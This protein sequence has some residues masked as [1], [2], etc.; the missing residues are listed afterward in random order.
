MTYTRLLRA[1][2]RCSVVG[3]QRTMLMRIK[4]LDCPRRVWGASVGFQPSLMAT[5]RPQSSSGATLA[6][7]P[8][9]S[10]TKK[11]R[12]SEA[13]ILDYSLTV[14]VLYGPYASKTRRTSKHSLLS[15]GGG[16]HQVWIADGAE[17]SVPSRSRGARWY[18]WFVG[19]RLSPTTIRH[20]FC[21]AED[22]RI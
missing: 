5:T 21:L 7:S 6:L 18:R 17:V 2:D 15:F 11:V 4:W 14:S 10:R 9:A 13:V 3:Y 8:P 22:P 1:R 12:L 16:D 19:R 20:R